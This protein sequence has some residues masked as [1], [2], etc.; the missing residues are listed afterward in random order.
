MIQ[1]ILLDLL[2]FIITNFHI[3]VNYIKKYRNFYLRKELIILFCT[4]LI[5]LIV[6]LIIKIQYMFRWT[7]L[8]SKDFKNHP[9][10]DM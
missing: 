10:D 9:S 5:N 7:N 6:N 8:F 2:L 4:L 1:I 3:Y